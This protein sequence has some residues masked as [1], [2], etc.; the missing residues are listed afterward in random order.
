[1]G[2]VSNGGA[3]TGGGSKGGGGGVSNGGAGTGG[4]SNSRAE[5][6]AQA[7]PTPIMV[8]LKSRAMRA[9]LAFTVFTDSSTAIQALIPSG[10]FI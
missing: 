8:T 7:T 1:M 9:Y 4:M 10:R 6:G 5:T 3:V 2:G